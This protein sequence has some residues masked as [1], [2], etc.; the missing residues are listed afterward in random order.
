MPSEPTP[1]HTAVPGAALANA[2]F[3]L[4]R[5][6]CWFLVSA[7]RLCCIARRVSDSRARCQ[8]PRSQSHLPTLTQ[9]YRVL[10]H[11]R[12]ICA[13]APAGFPGRRCSSATQTYQRTSCNHLAG[14]LRDSDK[15]KTRATL[16]LSAVC[17][18]A[19][20]A[21]QGAMRTLLA[22]AELGQKVGL[23]T[24]TRLMSCNVCLYIF[25]M[26]GYQCSPTAV[27]VSPSL[28]GS[29]GS[30]MTCVCV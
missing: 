10:T 4:Y 28:T 18:A 29:P 12:N 11:G 6:A 15:G 24:P 7:G 17:I 14:S 1:L 30:E 16:C 8:T 21:V 13:T 27:S 5:C 22:A 2:Y 19:E 20:H 25:D 9:S 23:E 26:L 3:K